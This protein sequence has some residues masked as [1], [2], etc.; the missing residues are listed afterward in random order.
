MRLNGLAVRTNSGWQN[1]ANSRNLQIHA[2]C[3]PLDLSCLPIVYLLPTR[4]GGKALIGNGIF[5]T[6]P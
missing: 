3:I 6:I 2:Q 1:E 5:L 4:E